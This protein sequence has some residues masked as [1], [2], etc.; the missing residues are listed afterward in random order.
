MFL[1]PTR[2]IHCKLQGKRRKRRA[3]RGS[4]KGRQGRHAVDTPTVG[5]GGGTRI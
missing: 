5:G 2:K 3:R 4:G 1:N